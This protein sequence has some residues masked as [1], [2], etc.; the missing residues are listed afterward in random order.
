MFTNSSLIYFKLWPGGNTTAIVSQPIPRK[1]QPR[2]A[3]QIMGNDRSIEQVGFIE[4][5][6]K[7]KAA[8]RLQMMGGEFCGNAARAAAYLWTMHFPRLKKVQFEVSGFS[9]L[10][11]A[12]I[13]DED[14]T[15]L[16]PGSFYIGS[17]RF[18]DGTLVDLAGI[19]HLVVSDSKK[20]DAVKLINRICDGYAAVG[21]ISTQ[22]K[23][24]V[25]E[26]DPLIWVRDTETFVHE[27]AC[28]SGSIAV[29]LADFE[30]NGSNFSCIRQ[31]SGEHYHVILSRRKG[32]VSSIELSG[33]VRYIDEGKIIGKT[34]QQK[35]Q[36]ASHAA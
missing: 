10:V 13:E 8:F 2:I 16:L 15:L 27:T 30:R 11:T 21:I 34:Q 1:L 7:K 26:I 35:V 22:R 9:K 17:R 24:S 14:V 20:R 12:L 31:P 18:S 6:R 5:S 4:R 29:A 25:V 36:L 28:G 32:R 19:R 23:R 3:R 33:T